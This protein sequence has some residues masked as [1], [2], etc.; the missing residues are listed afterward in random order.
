LLLFALLIVLEAF[1][2]LLIDGKVDGFVVRDSVFVEELCTLGW[3]L[4]GR[5]GGLVL[6]FARHVGD[7]GM[8]KEKQ[9]S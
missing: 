9:D 7:D 4:F 8:S 2:K 1:G 5:H 6:H 3:R